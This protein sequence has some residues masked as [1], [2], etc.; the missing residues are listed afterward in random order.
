MNVAHSCKQRSCNLSALSSLQLL[1]Q[2]VHATHML[3]RL[4]CRNLTGKLLFVDMAE[5]LDGTNA[6]KLLCR[7]VAGLS[8]AV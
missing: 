5:M 1:V 3:L 8:C 6:D 4:K 7:L 2:A